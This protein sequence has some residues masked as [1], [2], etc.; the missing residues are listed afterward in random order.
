MK[1][2]NKSIFIKILCTML[3]VM[4]GSCKKSFLSTTNTKNSNAAA[5]FQK[6]SDVVALV[7]SIYDGYQSSDL[8]KKA[9]WY[10]ANFLTH[11][12]YNDGADIQWNSFTI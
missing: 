1:I 12:W 8:L 6:S 7:N 3:I 11:D 5:T 9:I 4:A 10:Y 2:N